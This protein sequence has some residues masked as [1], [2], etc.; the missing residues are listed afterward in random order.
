MRSQKGVSIERISVKDVSSKQRAHDKFSMGQV[1]IEDLSTAKGWSRWIE[2]LSRI[3]RADKEH[4]NFAQWIEE[5][6]E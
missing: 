2:D 5:V 6:V 4:K 1:A 3:Y